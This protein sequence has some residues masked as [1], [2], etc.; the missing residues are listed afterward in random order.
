[1]YLLLHRV[2]NSHRHMVAPGD[3]SNLCISTIE[4]GGVSP[5]TRELGGRGL[6]A[7]NHFIHKL[8]K[9]EQP[10]HTGKF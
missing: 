10:I 7:S 5:G 6:G 2:L 4:P 3:G 9:K 1:M 8:E